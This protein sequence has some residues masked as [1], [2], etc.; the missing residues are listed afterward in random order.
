MLARPAA[1]PRLASSIAS[2]PATAHVL[3]SCAK[4]RGLGSAPTGLG[5]LTI[6]GRQ[7]CRRRLATLVCHAT[8]APTMRLAGGGG[9]PAAADTFELP[10]SEERR[11]GKECRARGAP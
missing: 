5:F 2:R 10:R 11:V 7:H 9:A 4:P 6:S 1:A 3:L 8:I